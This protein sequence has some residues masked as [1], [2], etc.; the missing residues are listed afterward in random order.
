VCLAAVTQY[1]RALEYVPKDLKTVALCA[2]A[3]KQDSDL[4]GYV[5]SALRKQVKQAAGIA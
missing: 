4:I 5:P 1:G 2:V 3:V